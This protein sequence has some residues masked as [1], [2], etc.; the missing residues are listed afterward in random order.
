[1]RKRDWIGVGGVFVTDKAGAAALTR[2]TFSLSGAY[3]L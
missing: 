2:T 3:H 1:L